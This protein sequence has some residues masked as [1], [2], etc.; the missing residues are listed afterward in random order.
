MGALDRSE[1]D[2]RAARVKPRGLLGRAYMA[3][4]EPFR[5]L[6]VYPALIREFERAWI[7]RRGSGI[8]P[9]PAG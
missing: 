1:A 8:S 4:I 9:R 6:V 2:S 5:Y 7:N 3:A